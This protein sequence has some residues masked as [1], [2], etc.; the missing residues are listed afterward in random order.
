MPKRGGPS[1][2]AERCGLLFAPAALRKRRWIRLF[3]WGRARSVSSEHQTEP[4]SHLY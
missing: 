2:R 3:A 4:P 1:T